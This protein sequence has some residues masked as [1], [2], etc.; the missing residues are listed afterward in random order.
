MA[1]VP[2]E[3]IYLDRQGVAWIMN[4][5]TKVIEVVLDQ[6]A[7]SLSPAQIHAEHPHLSLAQIYAALSYY[8]D[9]KTEM[10][11]EI[12]RRYQEVERLRSQAANQLTRKELEA[13]RQKA[14][15]PA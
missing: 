12:A 8:Y 15:N 10:D 1:A 11:E 13:R 6:N 14:G 2:V 4:T 7:Y 9:H 5:T 3:H